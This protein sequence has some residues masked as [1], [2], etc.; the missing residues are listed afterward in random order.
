MGKGKMDKL[1][2]A[3]CQYL[4]AT[5]GTEFAEGVL[6]SAHSAFAGTAVAP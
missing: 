4:A 6:L 3:F 5:S 1:F 2:G